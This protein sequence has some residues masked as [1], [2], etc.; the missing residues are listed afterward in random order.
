RKQWA[1]AEHAEKLSQYL[2]NDN[3]EWQEM[4][5]RQFIR[6]MLGDPD[7]GAPGKFDQLKLDAIAGCKVRRVELI[8]QLADLKKARKLWDAIG[9]G[10]EGRGNS[11]TLH[12]SLNLGDERDVW[13]FIH[14]DS[15]TELGGDQVGNYREQVFE[16]M[17]AVAEALS[18]VAVSFDPRPLETKYENS[19]FGGVSV[20]SSGIARLCG[21]YNLSIRT[22]MD[23]LL[24]QGQPYDTLEMLD[25]DVLFA[26]VRQVAP[27]IKALADNGKLAPAG[28]TGPSAT[29]HEVDWDG[30]KDV[31]PKIDRTSAGAAMR[32]HAVPQAMVAIYDNEKWDNDKSIPGYVR[33]LIYMTDSKGFYS[34]GPAT[35]V[36]ARYTYPAR[37]AAIFDEPDD[38]RPP[39]GNIR[40]VA[41]S[42]KS[43]GIIRY[44]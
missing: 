43:R 40:H 8:Q 17:L 29:F 28:T 35:T 34:V 6:K 19:L 1:P 30:D 14:G 38:A 37:F 24:R 36:A 2:T 22:V 33:Q 11:L 16:P 10:E 27:F 9:P 7:S 4:M 32:T 20:D 5:R 42:E 18:A 41:N 21:A 25:E 23:Q 39:P 31:G 12:L 26:Q 3:P 15:S 13:S 44:V